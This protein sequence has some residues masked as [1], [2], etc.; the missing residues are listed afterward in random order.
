MSCSAREVRSGPLRRESAAETAIWV[1]GPAM[2]VYLDYDVGG[3]S[4]QLSSEL[5]LHGCGAV[6]AQHPW[7]LSLGCSPEMAV[8]AFNKTPKLAG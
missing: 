2:R 7:P 4:S 5:K 3:V 8:S 1:P 6:F